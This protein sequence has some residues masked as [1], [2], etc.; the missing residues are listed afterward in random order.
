[1]KTAKQFSEL[2]EL[3]W[4]YNLYKKSYFYGRINESKMPRVIKWKVPQS[5][6][7]YELTIFT[8]GAVEPFHT[9]TVVRLHSISAV[10]SVLTRIWQAIIKFCRVN[11]IESLNRS[12][13][14]YLRI[15]R[16]I[17]YPLRQ[18]FVTLPI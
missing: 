1:M 13:T 18:P 5:K 14:E 3:C 6:L 17:I 15:I 2:K 10:P 9:R 8:V 11:K 4:D 7:L 12:K 16:Q